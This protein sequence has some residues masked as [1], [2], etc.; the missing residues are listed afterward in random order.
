MVKK[1]QHRGHAYD[2]DQNYCH[3]C[4]ETIQNQLFQAKYYVGMNTKGTP[5]QYLCG[6]FVIHKRDIMQKWH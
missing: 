3:F 6:K 2:F 4:L 5:K 1:R